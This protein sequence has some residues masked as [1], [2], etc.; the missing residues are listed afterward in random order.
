MYLPGIVE[1]VSA[2]L[3]PLTEALMLVCGVSMNRMRPDKDFQKTCHLSA[4][5]C[6]LMD[7]CPL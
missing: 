6:L 2:L 5:F 4:L 1:P 7:H 3:M